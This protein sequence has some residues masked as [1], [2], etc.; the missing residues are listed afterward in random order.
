MGR[1]VRKGD[2]VGEGSGRPPKGELD[3][4]MAGSSHEARSP[5]APNVSELISWPLE[6]TVTMA[7]GF[8]W[9]LRRPRWAYWIRK[10]RVTLC[11]A[12]L[13]SLDVDPAAE[14]SYPQ[15]ETVDEAIR[16]LSSPKTTWTTTS[17]RT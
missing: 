2:A 15:P 3:A 14:G 11:V 13:L 10:K 9:R 17:S 5:P 4:V 6:S 16:S 12:V 8:W 1:R 7:T